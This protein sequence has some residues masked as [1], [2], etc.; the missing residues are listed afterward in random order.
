MWHKKIGNEFLSGS[1]L[2]SPILTIAH[3]QTAFFGLGRR[4]RSFEITLLLRFQNR[5]DLAPNQNLS[6]L[7]GHKLLCS[8][9]I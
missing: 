1:I 9:I 2:K 5:S 3:P 7:D 4:F 8:R 6:F